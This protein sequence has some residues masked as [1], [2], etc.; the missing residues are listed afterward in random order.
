[1]GQVFSGLGASVRVLQR[2]NQK[3]VTQNWPFFVFSVFGHISGTITDR[4]VIEMFLESPFH[5]LSGPL[6]TRVIYGQS[7]LKK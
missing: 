7:D 3:R 1:M 2:K 6:Y 4:T 5:L